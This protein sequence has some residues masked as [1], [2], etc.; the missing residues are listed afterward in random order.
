[1]RAYPTQFLFCFVRSEEA[2][3]L[4]GFTYLYV[5]AARQGEYSRN[6]VEVM[7]LGLDLVYVN[8]TICA[9]C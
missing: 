7:S 2:V 6:E 4:D 1:M 5:V 8:L 9:Q 3:P